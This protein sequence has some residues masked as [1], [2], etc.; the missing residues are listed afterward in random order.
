VIDGVPVPAASSYA[1]DVTSAAPMLSGRRVLVLSDLALPLSDANAAVLGSLTASLREAGVLVRGE[2]ATVNNTEDLRLAALFRAGR[3]GLPLDDDELP[4]VLRR[5]LADTIGAA[6]GVV[7]VGPDAASVFGAGNDPL[8]YVLAAGGVT[9]RGRLEASS[10]PA[11][12]SNLASGLSRLTGPA[13][14]PGPAGAPVPAV[15]PAAGA[16]TVLVALAMP[17]DLSESQREHLHDAL[18][19]L[20]EAGWRIVDD[21]HALT[22]APTATLSIAWIGDGRVAALFQ[23]PGNVWRTMTTLEKLPEWAAEAA[24]DLIAAE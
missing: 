13:V 23:R 18:R 16:P 4:T 15:A 2:G 10:V 14:G 20:G 9:S 6:D 7:W 17:E 22:A 24:A 5:V 3:G 21:A 19:T 8:R 11:V 1:F 12:L